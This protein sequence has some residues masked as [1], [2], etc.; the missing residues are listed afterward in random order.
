MKFEL[1]FEK[2]SGFLHL[3]IFF[4]SQVAHLLL[5]AISFSLLLKITL[6]ALLSFDYLIASKWIFYIDMYFWGKLTLLY[7]FLIIFVLFRMILKHFLKKFYS[8]I[9]INPKFYFC[10]VLRKAL[11]YMLMPLLRKVIL[12]TSDIFNNKKAAAY[13]NHL[14]ETITQF[15]KSNNEIKCWESKANDNF[16][17]LAIAFTTKIWD[18]AAL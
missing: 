9:V 17:I 5:L 8:V 2:R 3:M 6:L 14:S 1:V 15:C 13:I 11:S 10:I 16:I 4:R 18:I 12:K 7:I